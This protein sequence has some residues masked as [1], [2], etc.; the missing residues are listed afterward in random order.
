MAT[1]AIT[2]VF[3]RHAYP[4]YEIRGAACGSLPC[5]NV[6]HVGQTLQALGGE[7]LT[8]AQLYTMVRRDVDI[9]PCRAERMLPDGISVHK[10]T[11]TERWQRPLFRVTRTYEPVN[12]SDVAAAAG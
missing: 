11:A 5:A 8:D 9:D 12:D 1:T 3:T 6:Q 2:H 4:R 10:L 7:R